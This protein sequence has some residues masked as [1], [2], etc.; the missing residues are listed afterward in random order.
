LENLIQLNLSENSFFR[1]FEYEEMLS[2]SMASNCDLFGTGMFSNTE[3]QIYKKCMNIIPISSRSY[4]DSRMMNDIIFYTRFLAFYA[5]GMKA[6]YV[7]SKKKLC[8][9]RTY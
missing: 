3:A 8:R 9:K 4:L 1:K 2:Y 6:S 5:A 7:E